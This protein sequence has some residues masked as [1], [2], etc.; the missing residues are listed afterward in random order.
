[1]PRLIR[2][3]DLTEFHHART[4]TQILAQATAWNQTYE[5]R[6]DLIPCTRTFIFTYVDT[7]NT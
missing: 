7:N 6:K 3:R 1:M 4:H 2:D 5:A